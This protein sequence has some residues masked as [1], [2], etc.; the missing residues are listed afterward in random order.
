MARTG[1]VGTRWVGGATCWSLLHTVGD[2]SSLL[3][4]SFEINKGF[5]Y[6]SYI[7][8]FNHHVFCFPFCSVKTWSYYVAQAGFELMILLLWPLKD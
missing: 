3:V 8:F 6:N 4:D 5:L 7:S 1:A 2:Y